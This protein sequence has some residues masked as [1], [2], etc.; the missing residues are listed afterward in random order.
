[1]IPQWDPGPWPTPGGPDLDPDHTHR[2]GHGHRAPSDRGSIASTNAASRLARG[3]ASLLG[4]LQELDLEETDRGQN[5]WKALIEV[6]SS[7]REALVR[8]LEQA[9]DQGEVQDIVYGDVVTALDRAQTA[10]IKAAKQL[11]I[12]ASKTVQKKL[13][14][15]QRPKLRLSS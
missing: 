14:I 1:M 6:T 8:F 12:L 11:D 3:L 5:E 15:H 9:E 13:D 7:K 2:P 10:E 4:W